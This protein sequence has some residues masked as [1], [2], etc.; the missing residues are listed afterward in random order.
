MKLFGDSDLPRGYYCPH[1][2]LLLRNAVQTTEGDRLCQA[3]FK[4]IAGLSN[5]RCPKCGL[6][7]NPS[8]CYPDMANRK[9]ISKVK[10][11]CNNCE[12]GCEW[13]GIIKDLETHLEDCHFKQ[14]KCDLCSKSVILE[15]LKHHKVNECEYRMS[16]C[17]YCEKK[18]IF[19][20]IEEHEESCDKAPINCEQCGTSLT[21]LELEK[22]QRDECKYIQCQVCQIFVSSTIEICQEIL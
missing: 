20:N 21:R 3:C 16:S 17:E 19:K 7:V 6:N 10:I 1:C 11:L 8:E 9:E 22:H 4:E 14:V 18:M 5:N 12:V 15:K 13:T 2:E